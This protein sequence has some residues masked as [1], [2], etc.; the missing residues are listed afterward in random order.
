ML[1]RMLY[2]NVAMQYRVPLWRNN[3]LTPPPPPPPPPPPHTP[4]SPP[5]PN[6]PQQPNTHTH[7]H[8]TPSPTHPNTPML[9]LHLHSLTYHLAPIDWPRTTT[10]IRDEKHLSVVIWWELYYMVDGIFLSMQSQYCWWHFRLQLR[11]KNYK[12]NVMICGS[13]WLFARKVIASGG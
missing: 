10:A 5:Q 1:V 7:T 3:L 6:T 13:W 2:C 8:P 11:S 12:W 9:Q 4:T